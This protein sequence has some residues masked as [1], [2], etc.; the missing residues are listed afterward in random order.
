MNRKH[1]ALMLAFLLGLAL[2]LAS[3]GGDDSANV[4]SGKTTG[5]VKISGAANQG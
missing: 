4:P 5:T 1:L 2:M 3:C